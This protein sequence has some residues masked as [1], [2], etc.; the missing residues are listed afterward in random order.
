ME[1]EREGGHVRRW[2]RHSRELTA[3]RKGRLGY[4]NENN[5]RQVHRICYS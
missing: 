3:E 5:E 4:R 1:R 2:H